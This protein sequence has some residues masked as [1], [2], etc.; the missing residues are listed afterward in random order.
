MKAWWG[1]EYVH[2]DKGSTRVINYNVGK[3]NF[4]VKKLQGHYFYRV[5]KVNTSQIYVNISDQHKV[6]PN[7]M[8][9]EVYSITSMAFVP[10]NAQHESNYEESWINQNQGRW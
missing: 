4:A 3:S 10:K 2:S 7:M 1:T 6:S 8:Y 5:I 9:W